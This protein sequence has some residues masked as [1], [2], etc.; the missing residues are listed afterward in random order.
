MAFFFCIWCTFQRSNQ[1]VLYIEFSLVDAYNRVDHIQI[2]G[3]IITSG[4]CQQLDHVTSIAM[5]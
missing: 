2:S 5:F 3:P 1:L 4:S